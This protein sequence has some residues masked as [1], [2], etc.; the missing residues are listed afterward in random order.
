MNKTLI[1]GSRHSGKTYRLIHEAINAKGII[2]C[3]TESSKDHIKSI[4][5][6]CNHIE[7]PVFTVAEMKSG[8]ARGTIGPLFVDEAQALLNEM[9]AENVG[10]VHLLGGYSFD[11]TNTDLFFLQNPI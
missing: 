2:I 8:K 7:V 5:R 4:L 6:E 11:T 3:A 1:L 10:G 9:L